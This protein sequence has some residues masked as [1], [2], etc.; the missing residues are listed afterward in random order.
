MRFVSWTIQPI[1]ASDQHSIVMDQDAV[2]E[3]CNDGR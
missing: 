3:G 1:G 2:L